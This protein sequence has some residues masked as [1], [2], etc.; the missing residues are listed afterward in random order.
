MRIL[1]VHNALRSFVRTDR[2]LLADVHEV[3]E[4]DLSVRT[5]LLSLPAW[6]A[7]ADLVYVWFAGMH[8]LPVVHA[9]WVARK[10]SIVV[11]G[12]YD[13][14]ADAEIGYGHMAHPVKRHIVRAICN[15]ASRLSAFSHY[16]AR[17]TA[18]HTGTCTPITVSYCGFAPAD[19]PPPGCARARMALSVGGVSRESLWRKGHLPFVRAAA[20]LP[21]VRFVLAGPIWD[22]AGDFLLSLSTPNVEIMGQV[23]DETLDALYRDASVYVQPSQHEGFGRSVVEA[24]LGGCY[25]VVSKRGS[26]PE[27]V[28]TMGTVV[29]SVDPEALATA[30]EASLDTACAVRR[31]ISAGAA[32]MYSLERRRREILALVSEVVECRKGVAVSREP[33]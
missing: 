27:V 5:R 19:A 15:R 12:G 18:A 28:A 1:F 13:V 26:L 25:P 21:D 11:V 10:P 29:D 16:A 3:D 31:K 33:R 8:A 4:L 6:L 24:M 17:E 7:R 23:D 14:A 9:A 2:D 22:D 20:H 30:I 32:A